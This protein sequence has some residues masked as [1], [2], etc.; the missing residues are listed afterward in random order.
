MTFGK[1]KDILA[2]IAVPNGT[3]MSLCLK[4]RN[5]GTTGRDLACRPSVRVLLKAFG[6]ESDR[7][8]HRDVLAGVW[9]CGSAVLAAAFPN[10]G[11][12]FVGVALTFDLAVLTMEYVGHI[13]RV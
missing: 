11:I 1:S 7:R 9:A 6:Q 3:M 12:G 8:V 2:T 4:V 5:P 13:V 10:L